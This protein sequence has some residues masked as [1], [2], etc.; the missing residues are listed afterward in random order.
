[1]SSQAESRAGRGGAVELA[2]RSRATCSISHVLVMAA[3]V[4]PLLV[5]VDQLES[6][7]LSPFHER[8]GGGETGDSN[9]TVHLYVPRRKGEGH[10]GT[11]AIY[12]LLSTRCHED[13]PVG[14]SFRRQ[15]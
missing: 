1:M 7:L 11:L 12:L 13:L 10:T 5:K 2:A 6:E 14:G 8:P 3:E 9:L 15:R 4:R